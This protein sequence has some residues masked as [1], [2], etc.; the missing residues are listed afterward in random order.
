LD[1]QTKEKT[2]AELQDKLRKAQL[3]ILA[4]YTGMNVEKINALRN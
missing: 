3:A 1:K 4:G 2:I